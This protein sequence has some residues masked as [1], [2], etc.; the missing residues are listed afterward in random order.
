MQ[1]IFTVNH[2]QKFKYLVLSMG[3][4]LKNHKVKKR[5]NSRKLIKFLISFREVHMLA[6]KKIN[7]K[8][9]MVKFSMMIPINRKVSIMNH[10]Q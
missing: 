9:K 2:N 4:N 3:K 5:S 10:N 1:I 7:T 8:I 6:P